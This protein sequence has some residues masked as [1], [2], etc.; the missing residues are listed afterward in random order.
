MGFVQIKGSES[1]PSASYEDTISKE[2][3]CEYLKG[4]VLNNDFHTSN[5][6][7]DM[8]RHIS[9]YWI[10]SS[11]NTYLLG[12]QLVGKSSVEAYI[13]VLQQGCRCVEIDAWDG[14]DGEP[15]VYHGHTLTSKITFREVIEVIK[16]Y[17]FV[18]SDFPV[19]IN[20]ENHCSSQQQTKMAGIISEELGSHLL[21]GELSA[22]SSPESLKR[23]ILIRGKRTSVYANRTSSG[24]VS[25]GEDGEESSSESEADLLCGSE[26]YSNIIN[27]PNTKTKCHAKDLSLPVSA[28]TSKSENALLR[29]ASSHAS[30]LV[31]FIQTHLVRVY[32]SGK[33]VNS[34]NYDPRVHWALG[35]QIVALN[36]QTNDEGMRWNQALFKDNGGCGYVLKPSKLRCSGC[37]PPPGFITA[38]PPTINPKLH[39]RVISGQ[40][41]PS[42]GG[43]NNDI[44]DPYVILEVDGL[45]GENNRKRTKTVS[46]NGLNPYWGEEFS[47]DVLDMDLSFLGFT[48]M[49][50]D[51]NSADDFLAYNTFR[52][53][54]LLP[55]YR[56]VPLYD[57]IGEV[58]PLAKIFVYVKIE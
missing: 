36:H 4:C 49:D 9:H 51:R 45:R 54:S 22:D 39:I 6:H 14:E 31:A 48:V 41:L 24:N 20:I 43:A 30:D 28:T 27:L 18:A 10:N 23:K 55:G 52:I 37:L 33:R 19:I 7:Q 40:N 29:L 38:S 11:H 25:M 21:A 1:V 5:I 35:C 8:S 57:A 32:P 50:Y 47:F 44:V 15:I 56:H 17:A 34:S 42:D 26:E 2:E 58:I 46:N 13:R 12:D 16:Q 3:F 53:N